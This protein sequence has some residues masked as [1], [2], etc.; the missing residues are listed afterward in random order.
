MQVIFVP[1][2]LFYSSALY[3]TLKKT[4]FISSR[5][6]KSLE[7]IIHQ[8]LDQN[9]IDYENGRQLNSLETAL[10]TI[11]FFQMGRIGELSRSQLIEDCLRG[12]LGDGLWAANDF[13]YIPSFE[14]KLSIIK[15]EISPPV[16]ACGHWRF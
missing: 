5:L 7:L 15:A 6:L 3:C 14:G 4:N 1:M 12:Q 13:Y 2:N 16:F 10:M 8:K 11:S 9:K